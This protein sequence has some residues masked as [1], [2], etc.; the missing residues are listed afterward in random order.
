MADLTLWMLYFSCSYFR[1]TEL[2]LT[3]SSI[4][5]SKFFLAACPF[6]FATSCCIDSIFFIKNFFSLSNFVIRI[7]SKLFN[8]SSSFFVLLLLSTML[9]DAWGCGGSLGD[10]F[11]CFESLC[12]W[13]PSNGLGGNTY[14]DFDILSCSLLSWRFSLFF[15]MIGSLSRD[16]RV[17]IWL[18]ILVYFLSS[19][20]ISSLAC[21]F[22]IYNL[23]GLE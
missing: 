11:D 19:I 2:S 4:F 5:I 1:M 20:F 6:Y 10:N 3:S 14:F 8:C 12:V 17:S 15:L 13:I 16:L 9:L 23:S 7:F 21:C 18:G 22:G